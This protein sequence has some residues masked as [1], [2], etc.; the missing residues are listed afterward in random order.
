[1]DSK[2][3]P[4]SADNDDNVAVNK[5]LPYKKRVKA[6]IPCTFSAGRG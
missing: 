4:D 3:K 2:R 6:H 1:M 5:E